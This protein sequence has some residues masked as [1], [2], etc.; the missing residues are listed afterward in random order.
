MNDYLGKIIWG[1]AELL[2]YLRLVPEM[3][4]LVESLA[5]WVGPTLQGQQFRFLCNAWN[6]TI[7]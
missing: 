6:V 3:G 2:W 7:F 1:G 4:K 5:L